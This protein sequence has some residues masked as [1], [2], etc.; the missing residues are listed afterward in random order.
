MPSTPPYAPRSRL[1]SAAQLLRTPRHVGRRPQKRSQRGRYRSAAKG[2][3]K[4]R[5]QRL[6]REANP[7]AIGDAGTTGC[8]SASGQ[9]VGYLQQ[10]LHQSG[11]REASIIQALAA[12]AWSLAPG[13][14]DWGREHGH[15]T[16]RVRYQ[17]ALGHSAQRLRA[18]A[19]R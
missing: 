17:D 2:S 19:G 18:L 16:R 5:W 14:N 8:C 4:S 3:R 10:L 7:S 13:L 1:F 12:D 15:L 9:I 6:P 11:Q